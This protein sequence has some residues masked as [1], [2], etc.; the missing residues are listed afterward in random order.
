MST[1]S[2]E[3]VRDAKTALRRQMKALRAALSDAER[4]SAAQKLAQAPLPPTIL[5]PHGGVV[6]GYWPMKGEIDP[7]PM[8]RVLAQQGYRLA[9]PRMTPH[10]LDFHLWT[11]GDLMETGAFGAHEPRASAPALAP[12]LILTPLLAFDEAG[13]RL[14]FGKGFYDRAFAARPE[15]KRVGLAYAFQRVDAVPGE[16]HDIPLD[17]VMVV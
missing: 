2:P 15:A 13:G 16:A 12:D 11:P 4:A 6:A 17:A 9:L 5:P 8:M 1:I 3:S 10:G 7:L 14:G